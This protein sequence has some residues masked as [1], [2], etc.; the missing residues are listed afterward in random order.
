L[1]EKDLA[2]DDMLLTLRFAKVSN[3]ENLVKKYLDELV[4]QLKPIPTN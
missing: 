3:E 4:A 1:L 2:L